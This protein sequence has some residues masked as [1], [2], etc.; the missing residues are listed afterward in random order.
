MAVWF[1][2]FLSRVSGLD[3]PRTPFIAE[4]DFELLICL[5]LLNAGVASVHPHAQLFFVF[6]FL[7]TG[8]ELRASCLLSKRSA[9]KAIS[10]AVGCFETVSCGPGRPGLTM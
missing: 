8:I 9:N 5:Y 1:L 4:D 10:Y 7:G 2:F 6:V 3:W